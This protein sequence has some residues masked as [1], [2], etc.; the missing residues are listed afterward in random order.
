MGKLHITGIDIGHNSIKAVALKSTHA[1]YTL[2]GC[3]EIA[4]THR[5]FSDN[6]TLNYQEIVKK[7][8]ELRKGLP[9]F[10]RH[11]ALSI[12]ENAVI[13]KTLQLESPVLQGE[14][15]W[16]ITEALSRQVA[17]SLQDV[18]IDFVPSASE[19]G[20]YHVYIIKRDMVE[21]WASILHKA[22]FA[23]F[24][25]A[26]DSQ[27]RALLWQQTLGEQEAD[28]WLVDVGVVHTLICGSASTQMPF[29][30]TLSHVPLGSS[31]QSEDESIHA[32]VLQLQ[33]EVQLFRSVHG[34]DKVQ[35]LAL[36]G[37]NAHRLM[38][39][40]SQQLD[41]P[42]RILTSLPLLSDSRLYGVPWAGALGIGL[43]AQR[44]WASRYAR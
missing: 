42:C 29:F 41:V 40:G 9:W 33:R 30:K 34:A 3:H 5:V 35:A 39:K 36:V 26:T 24:Y 8:K 18:Q 11:V 22:G 37:E 23:P 13:T 6:H 31:S 7:L 14:E 4:V 21:K 43:C 44:W 20:M 25:L 15:I 27:A 17:F 2:A 28:T 10:Y 32:L 12:P 1:T 16:S 19:E 38:E